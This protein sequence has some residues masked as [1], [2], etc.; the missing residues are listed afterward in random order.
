MALLLV[1]VVLL[2]ILVI[3]PWVKLAIIFIFVALF[4]AVTL[5]LTQARRHE[6]FVAIAT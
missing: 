2:Y 5:Y 4:T 6:I 1:P 3:G